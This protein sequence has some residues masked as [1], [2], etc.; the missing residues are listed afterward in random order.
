MRTISNDTVFLVAFCVNHDIL[1]LVNP[2]NF[3]KMGLWTIA[4][5][6]ADKKGN[7]IAG[8]LMK[9]LDITPQQGR[10]ILDQRE[11]IRTLCDNLK[12]CLALIIK[13]KSLCEQK[14]RLF[15]DRMTKCREILTSKQTVKLII[16]INDNTQLLDAVCPGWGTEHIHSKSTL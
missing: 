2:T 15:H 7:T 8:I 14:T 9:E 10:K 11:K 5:N 13:L 1:R 3:T 4:Q 16:W 6:S 12:E